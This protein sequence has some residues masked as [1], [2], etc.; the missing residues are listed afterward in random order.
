MRTIFIFDWRGTLDILEDKKEFLSELKE[1]YPDCYMVLNSGM[2][3][4]VPHDI[5]KMFED[6]YFKKQEW[7]ILQTVIEEIDHWSKLLSPIPAS[8]IN[9]VVVVDDQL[10]FDNIKFLSK[11]LQACG[12]KFEHIDVLGFRSVKNMKKSLEQQN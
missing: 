3:Y 6:T 11:R 1:K 10:D 4:S 2:V 9:K 8:E 12:T 5:K 7:E